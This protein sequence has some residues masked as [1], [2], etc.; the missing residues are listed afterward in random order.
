MNTLLSRLNGQL[1]VF[2]VAQTQFPHPDALTPFSAAKVTISQFSQWQS[3]YEPEGGACLTVPYRLRLGRRAQG[4]AIISVRGGFAT[5]RPMLP[6]RRAVAGSVVRTVQVLSIAIALLLAVILSYL[7]D[8][9]TTCSPH[10]LPFL[11]LRFAGVVPGRRSCL[12]VYFL[13][14]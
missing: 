3:S 13:P 7:H 12:F 1:E 9:T 10:L 8:S 2:K 5:P 14:F 6:T 11:S 4:L